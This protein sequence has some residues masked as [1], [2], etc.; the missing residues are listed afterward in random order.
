MH[1]WPWGDLD[2]YIIYIYI[3][4]TST[5][6]ARSAAALDTTHKMQSDLQGYHWQVG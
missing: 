3:Y 2:I 1:I 4:M 6:P 5:S